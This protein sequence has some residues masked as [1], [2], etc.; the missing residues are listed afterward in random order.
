MSDNPNSQLIALNRIKV[1]ALNVRRTD[2]KVDID[3]LAA[4]I[5]AHGLLQNLS[6]I[7]SGKDAFEVIAGARR[8]AALKSLAKAGKLAKDYPVPCRV[9]ERDAG[10][11]A[12]LVENVHRLAMSA[13]DEV[14]AFAA[15]LADGLGAA[16][17]ARRFGVTCRH[18]DQRL[19]LAGLSKLIKAAWKRGEVS[20]EAAKAFCLNGDHAQQN[21]VFRSLSKP[22]THAGLV[23]ARLMEKRVRA[24]DR[25]AVFVGLDVYEAEGGKVLRDL[26]DSDAVYLDEPALLM[27][28]AEQKLDAERAT[29]LAR[30]W[31][32]VE[33]SVEPGS[34]G[35]SPTQRIYPH[36]RDA[37]EE[38]SRQLDELQARIDALDTELD[39]CEDGNDPRWND[40][41]DLEADYETIRQQAKEWDPELIPLAGVILSVGRD[42][43]VIAT[44]G[45]VKKSEA[46]KVQAIHRKRAGQTGNENE[47]QKLE[48]TDPGQ[49]RPALPKAVSWDLTTAR[50]RAIRE[51]LAADPH[52]AL[53]VSVHAMI[54]RA[55]RYDDL[56][57][58]AVA[59]HPAQI[60][61]TDKLETMRSSWLSNLPDD[62]ASLWDWCL[63][64]S[65][66]ALVKAHAILVSAAIDLSHEDAAPQDF[67][68]QEIGDR[69]AQ[70]FDLDMAGYWAPDFEFLVR[71]PKAML[72]DISSISPKAA[73]LDEDARSEL[74]KTLSRLRKHELAV[75]VATELEEGGWL[76]D[77]LVTP[78]A[79]GSLAL[80]Q[81]G[82]AEVATG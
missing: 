52:I 54:L 16:D 11:E 64:A 74:L 41:D 39:E 37:T 78:C 77:L 62:E 35:V 5:S 19:A 43:A 59:A 76:P 9:L 7:P 60:D 48:E 65:I 2:R 72:L 40:R 81:R 49:A 31:G 6:V 17:I 63:G 32:W 68:R 58:V 28:L 22:I 57:G 24:S 79:S 36:W 51:K 33:I 14:D 8:L 20:L 44:E 53:A 38:E 56:A 69:L 50:T 71:L 18:V 75:R 27:R 29:W 34:N 25:L 13:P 30:G 23:R 42:G 3:A 73:S 66:D 15:L 12:S 70:V 26:F 67:R 82:V 46:A 45:V 61:D 47:G 10:R 80:T 4:S 1:S 55:Y 21:A